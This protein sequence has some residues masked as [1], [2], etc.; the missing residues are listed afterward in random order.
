MPGCSKHQSPLSDYREPHVFALVGIPLL[1]T[2][3]AATVGLYLFR[4]W[5]PRLY[6][7]AL[8]VYAGFALLSEPVTLSGPSQ[9]FVLLDGAISGAIATWLLIARERLPFASSRTV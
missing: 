5:G 7:V 6:F 1:V 4:P 9:F 3:V 8:A 2:P